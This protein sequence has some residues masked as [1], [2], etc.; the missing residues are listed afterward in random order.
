MFPCKFNVFTFAHTEY[1]KEGVDFHVMSSSSSSPPERHTNTLLLWCTALGPGLVLMHA[2]GYLLLQ[3]LF[4]CKHAF[5]VP[6][7][8][9]VKYLMKYWIWHVGCQ[10]C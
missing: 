5:L 6:D 2:H 9:K 10:L 1:S 3:H 8:Q 4:L 7:E